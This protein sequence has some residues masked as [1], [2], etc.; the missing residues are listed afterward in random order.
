MSY[1]QKKLT[2]IAST[3]LNVFI[4]YC[5]RNIAA[6]SLTK[7]CSLSF[8]QSTQYGIENVLE[9]QL[10]HTKEFNDCLGTPFDSKLLHR[11]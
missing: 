6:N 10:S 1:T 3:I 9:L 8:Y 7:W 5:A 11:I 2:A 4:H